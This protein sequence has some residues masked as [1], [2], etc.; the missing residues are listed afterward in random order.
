MITN[1]SRTLSPLQ[2]RI[3]ELEARIISLEEQMKED[4]MTMLRASQ[5]GSGRTIAALSISIHESKK[6]IETL[7]EELER[8]SLELH[9]KSQEFEAIFKDL[10]QKS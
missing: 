2:E 9:V 5:Q 10:E 3:R 7:F 6:Q 1:R 8:L 4:N